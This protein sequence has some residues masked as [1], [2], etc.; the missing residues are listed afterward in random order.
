MTAQPPDPDPLD[1]PGLEPGGGV[2]P[3]DTPPD[4]AHVTQSANADPVPD[5][6]VT[7]TAVASFVALA[8]F[9]L[10]FLAVAVYLVL[11]MTGGAG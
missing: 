9:A 11:R 4:S 7:P 5:K 6:R 3:G 2:Q 8:V 1:T 10:L